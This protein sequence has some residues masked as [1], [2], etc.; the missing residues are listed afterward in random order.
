MLAMNAAHEPMNAAHE[1]QS[2]FDLRYYTFVCVDSATSHMPSVS[3]QRHGH[4][5]LHFPHILMCNLQSE[6]DNRY[7]QDVG[8]NVRNQVHCMLSNEGCPGHC[9]LTRIQQ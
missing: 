4:R 7:S 3:G 2:S 6:L 1:P 5:H 8:D 9:A